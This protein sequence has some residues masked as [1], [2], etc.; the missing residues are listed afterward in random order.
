[1]PG[2]PEMIVE[3]REKFYYMANEEKL[4]KFMR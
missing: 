3:Y 2:D 4:L 1:M